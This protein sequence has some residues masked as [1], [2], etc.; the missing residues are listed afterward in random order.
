MK[1]LKKKNK[2]GKKPDKFVTCIKEIVDYLVLAEEK[3]R[4][5]I[6]HIKSR[7]FRSNFYYSDPFP[8]LNHKVVTKAINF[9]KFKGYL[10]RQQGESL[11]KLITSKDSESI[12]LAVSTLDLIISKEND[13]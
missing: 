8:S 4:N 1:H 11:F 13:R 2:R 3:R 6:I 5:H 10:D 9:I 7:R 12:Q